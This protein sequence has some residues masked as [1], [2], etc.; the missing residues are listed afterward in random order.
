[1]MTHRPRVGGQQLFQHLVAFEL[2]HLHVEQHDVGK[3][4]FTGGEQLVGMTEGADRVQPVVL[5][6]VFQVIAKI[7]IVVENGEIHQAVVAPCFTLR[8]IGSGIGCSFG[9][10]PDCQFNSTPAVASAH[11]SG[12]CHFETSAAL[13]PVRRRNGSTVL[14]NDALGHGEPKPGALRVQTR[15][16]EGFKNIGQHVGR[17]AGAVVFHRDRD[18][19]L[20]VAIQALANG[21][22]SR[23]RPGWHRAHCAAD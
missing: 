14:V 8:L 6:R 13:R 20:R 4:L 12:Q 21:P 9:C 7:G 15:G 11:G 1:M 19:G 23:P 16:D 3:A 10:G 17:D 22:R 2:A 5:Q 18:P